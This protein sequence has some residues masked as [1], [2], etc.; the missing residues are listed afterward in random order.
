MIN[1]SEITLRHR[2]EELRKSGQPLDVAH[3]IGI[4]VPLAAELAD[5]HRQGYNFF[6]YPGALFEGQDGLYHASANSAR[7][8]SDARDAACLPPE[9]RG[10]TPGQARASVYGIGAILYELI[11]LHSVGPGMRR[12]SEMAANISPDLELI[13]TKA[14]VADPAHRP[15][16]LNALAQAFYQINNTVSL[17]PPAAD[18]S[19]LDH[20]DGFDVDVSMSLLP[21]APAGTPHV[22]HGMEAPMPRGLDLANART[23]QPHSEREHLLATKAR[24]ESDPRP[25]YVVVRGGMDHGPF[26][27]VE[28]LQQ[29]ASHSFEEDD[30]I[31]DT[32]D[33]TEMLLRES[34]DFAA[35]GRHARM[36][37]HEK[38][39]KVA[40]AH[41]VKS[42]SRR[43]A[44]KTL[45]GLAGIFVILAG[46]GAWYLQSRGQ[47]NDQIKVVEEVAAN[48]ESDQG[49]KSTKKGGG[50]ARVKGTVGGFPQLSG[51][52]SCE[53]AQAAYM[54]EMK[55]GEKGRAD[56]TVGQLG[57]VLNTGSYLNACGVPSNMSVNVC[58]AIQ[59]GRAVGVTVTTKP[60]DG[61]KSSCIA[62]QIRRLNFPS[63]PK[64]DVTRTSFAAQ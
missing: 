56:L 15:D 45:V 2:I 14:L 35:F 61:G 34:P 37:R 53:S 17:A 12:P 7:P 52:M 38:A 51:G 31:R 36:G 19:H 55:M 42:E 60:R 64:L 22:I 50:G 32:V 13:L 28:L 3:A 43:T 62:G 58:A 59:N 16:D 47:K 27:A 20:D 1:S 9:S 48:V 46:V 33:K 29:I 5:Q 26:A 18:V 8:P 10:V 49:L 57:A 6:L 21:P 24:L 54:E 25:R 30:L 11:T 39:E 44:G 4:I 63:N 41:A 23:A 40:L